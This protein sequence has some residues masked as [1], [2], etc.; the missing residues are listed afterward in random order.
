MIPWNLDYW[1]TFQE[2]RSTLR[3]FLQEEIFRMRNCNFKFLTDIFLPMVNGTLIGTFGHLEYSSV[4]TNNLCLT[5]L[6]PFET[7]LFQYT[8]VYI[9]MIYISDKDFNL[10]SSEMNEGLER[11]K[12]M[13]NNKNCKVAC[14][15]MCLPEVSV[16]RMKYRPY[17]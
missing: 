2:Q 14:I 9:Q 3:Q 15:Y 1:E 6:R 8:Y 17:H 7:I 16:R 5:N 4:Q 11:C 13:E 12:E 10:C